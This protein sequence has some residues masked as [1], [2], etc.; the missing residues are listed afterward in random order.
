MAAV[1]TWRQTVGDLPKEQSTDTDTLASEERVI[2]LGLLARR[3]SGYVSHLAI[4]AVDVAYI[5]DASVNDQSDVLRC[6]LRGYSGVSRQFTGTGEHRDF[7][8]HCTR[9]YS[10]RWSGAQRRPSSM[11]LFPCKADLA[12]ALRVQT[13]AQQVCTLPDTLDECLRWFYLCSMRSA[14]S[15][16]V[17]FLVNVVVEPAEFH[18]SVK[19]GDVINVAGTW[20]EGSHGATANIYA[21][22]G[23]ITVLPPGSEW[24]HMNEAPIFSITGRLHKKITSPRSSLV[25]SVDRKNMEPLMFE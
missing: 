18:S 17:A 10:N 13:T 9:R 8:T 23:A 4:S 16:D 22:S 25:V 19:T 12:G 7:V 24:I 6:H 21:D 20:R 1:H 2:W 14:V 5:V 11:H 3:R 15:P